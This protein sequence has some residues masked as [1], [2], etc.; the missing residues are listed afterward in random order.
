MTKIIDEFTYMARH[1]EILLYGNYNK[2][3]NVKILTDSEPTLESIAST[4]QIERKGLRM[5]VHE[6]KD[7]LRDGEI[8]SYQWILTKKIWADGLTKEMP[9]T[10]GIRNLLKNGICDMVQEDTNKVICQDDEIKMINIRNRKRG[11]SEKDD[12]NTPSTTS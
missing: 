5:L 12:D 1:V 11:K 8:T 2:K 10:D 9:M 7:K 6:M 4:R 3:M